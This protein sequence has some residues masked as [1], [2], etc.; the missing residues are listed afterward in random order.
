[1]VGGCP[2]VR[3]NSLP[4]MVAT[5]SINPLTF[6]LRDKYALSP[7]E[8]DLR[9]AVSQHG[10][11]YLSLKLEVLKME[12]MILFG[13]MVGGVVLIG[14]HSVRQHKREREAVRRRMKQWRERGLV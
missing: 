9:G 8:V 5:L 10:V 2:A 13:A 6:N 4:Y 14:R 7:C 3:Q 1:M 11:G 12:V